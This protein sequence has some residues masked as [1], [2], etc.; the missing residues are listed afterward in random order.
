MDGPGHF[1]TLAHYNQWANRR[2]YAATAELSDAQFREDK[3][4]FFGSVRGTLN[5]LLVADRI[6]LRRIEGTG[7]QHTRLDEIVCDGFTELREAREE[8]DERLIRVLSGLGEERLAS[9]LAYRNSRG[10]DVELP[11]GPV[12]THIINHQTHHRGQAHTLLSQFG[13]EAPVLDFVY[14]LLQK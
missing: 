10:E 6:W 3:G 4:A 11:L 2:L 1:A 7:P 14:F 5:H 13:R 8:E 9:I 12:L